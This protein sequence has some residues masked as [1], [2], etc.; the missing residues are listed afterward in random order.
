MKPS[1]CKKY[2]TLPFDCQMEDIQFSNALKKCCSTDN[3]FTGL[4]L[5]DT[6]A[7]GKD[8]PWAEKKE[9]NIK[10]ARIYK[11]VDIRK[12][13]RLLSCCNY[14]EFKESTNGK[15]TLHKMSSCRVRLCPLCAWRRSL[16]V[17]YNNLSIVEYLKKKFNYEFIFLTLTIPNVTS[18]KLNDT[19]DWLDAS[20][21]R[22]YERPEWKA[23]V[24]GACRCVE[25]TH[26]V[27]TTSPSYDTYHP[28]IHYMLA[29]NKSYFKSRNYMSAKA[30]TELWRS[31]LHYPL[32]KPLSV[33]VK[34]CYGTTEKAVAECSKY[35]TKDTEYVVDS[36]FNLSI[37]S[38]AT[39]DK[40]LAN[41]RLLTYTGAFREAKRKL[42]LEDEDKGS[43]INVGE[44]DETLENDF[45]YVTYCWHSGYRQFIEVKK[46]KNR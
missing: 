43:L 30:W 41:R 17:F 25:V 38:V 21:H 46:G 26:N 37:D 27:D 28:H 8:R 5:S 1:S 20:V 39:L 16:K 42:K 14:L 31:C 34:K 9:R 33:D 13:Y 7:V 32:N 12:M 15:L 44:L 11:E 18:D 29:V 22:M 35:S 40:A 10:L 3:D 36:N 45:R 23:V 2:N 24:K 4:I 19:L 6:D